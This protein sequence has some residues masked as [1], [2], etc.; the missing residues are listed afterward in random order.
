MNEQ[1]QG[2][3]KDEQQAGDFSEMVLL[4]SLTLRRLDDF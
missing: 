1:G 3:E 4:E 2:K